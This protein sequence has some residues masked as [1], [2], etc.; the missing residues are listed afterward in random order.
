MIKIVIVIALKNC[1]KN[2][3][4]NCNENRVKNCDEN[5]VKE[6]CS[7]R[8]KMPFLKISDPV[9]RD[10]IVKEYLETK[11]NILD[12]LLSERTGEQ[13]LQIDLSKIF[14]PITETQ[15]TTTREITEGLRPIR[16]G[17][18]KIPQTI[19]FSTFPSIQ[20]PEGEEDT[21]YIGAV[22]EKYLRKFATKSEADTTYGLYY[23]NGN[24][25]IEI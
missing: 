24:F 7:N 9:K 2:C 21:Q 20:A 10:S 17:I 6:L 25:Y 5:R 18:E 4:E 11:K 3:D 19:T 12:N 1:D 15:K 23:R 14:K 8:K 16:E 22:A 13:Q